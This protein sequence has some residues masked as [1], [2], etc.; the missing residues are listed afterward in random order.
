[1]KKLIRS[2]ISRHAVAT[3][4]HSRPNVKRPYQSGD[5]SGRVRVVDGSKVREQVVSR[6]VQTATSIQ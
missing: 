3:P 4:H 2:Q 1:M 5:L 6:T